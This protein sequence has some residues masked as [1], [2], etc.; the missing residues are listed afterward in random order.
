MDQTNLGTWGVMSFTKES[1]GHFKDIE[2]YYSPGL[3]K[4][5]RQ[6]LSFSLTLVPWNLPSYDCNQNQCNYSQEKRFLWNYLSIQVAIE[7]WSL[8]MHV[9]YLLPML[10]HAEATYLMFR[11]LFLPHSLCSIYTDSFLLSYFSST[12][13][14]H[15]QDQILPIHHTSSGSLK[16][17]PGLWYLGSDIYLSQLLRK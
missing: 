11:C 10:L 5:W 4:V 12:L 8:Y 1:G 14:S 3:H 13:L 16:L 15:H 17:Q 2:C 9:S 7:T 6:L